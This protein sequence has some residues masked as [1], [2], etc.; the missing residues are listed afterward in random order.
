MNLCVDHRFETFFK[1]CVVHP[2][3]CLQNPNLGDFLFSGWWLVSQ[4]IPCLPPR[5]PACSW[6]RT[7]S[8]FYWP[9]LEVGVGLVWGGGM[10]QFEGMIPKW[11]EEGHTVRRGGAG[12]A[13]RAHGWAC[14]DT[15]DCGQDNKLNMSGPKFGSV[16]A[17]G[18]LNWH[19]V[20]N[21]VFFLN[22]NSSRLK[23]HVFNLGTYMKICKIT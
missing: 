23:I 8:F 15:H 10:W 21:V 5:R 19:S 7:M 11:G 12:W 22:Q 2:N 3:R 16:W 18:D 20:L 6:V 9:G 17:V 4:L 13:R 1:V 14:G